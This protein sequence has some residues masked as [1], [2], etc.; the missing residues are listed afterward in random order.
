MITTNIPSPPLVERIQAARAAQHEWAQQSVRKRLRPV[1][2]LRHLLVVE[3]DNMCAAVARDIG[4][5]TEETLGGDILPLAAGCRFLEMEAERLLQPR[6]V[7]RRLRPLWLWGQS[8]T[9]HRR[10]RGVVG[11]IGTWNYPLYLN[12]VQMVQ[13]LTAGNA[14]VWKPSEVSPSS[15]GLLHRLLLQAGYPADLVQCLEATREAGAALIDADLNHLVFTGSAA[16]GRHIAGRLGERL[17]SSTLELSGCDAFFVLDDADL[18]LSARAAWFGTVLNRGQTC[19]AA[20]RAFVQRSDYTAFCERLTSLSAGATPVSVALA[21]QKQQGERLV[22]AALAD[23]GRLLTPPPPGAHAADLFQPAIVADARPDM[24][25][26]REASFAPVLAVLP[27]DT[28]EQALAMEASCVYALGA[29]IF[30]ST[31]ARARSLAA[32]LRAGAVTVNDVIVPTA[33][34]ATPFGGRGD[35][36]WGVTQGAEGLLEMTVPQVVSLRTDKLRLHYQLTTPQAPAQED[37]LRG[38]LESSHGASM[39]QRWSGWRRLW[40]ALWK[41]K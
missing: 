27:F 22:Q 16:T 21:A 13:A 2:A 25:L 11:V 33:H 15:A 7:P 17:I 31:P 8:D 32:Q 20:R 24:A 37:L 30:T 23:G 4:K 10:P 40:R 19:L 36:G 39:R 3:C 41:G 1:R 28:V 9:V 18:A 38:L 14:V 5:T 12:G 35:S 29:S 26:C 34:P 6:H